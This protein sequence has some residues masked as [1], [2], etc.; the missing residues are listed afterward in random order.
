MDKGVHLYF[1]GR[2]LGVRRQDAW[3]TTDFDRPS[4]GETDVSSAVFSAGTLTTD[5]NPIEQRMV[6]P[7]DSIDS[8]LRL[9][10]GNVEYRIEGD[11]L[12]S[13]TGLR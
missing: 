7:A 5:K 12:G 3:G 1:T 4:G 6:P 9:G 2:G 10:V 13:P 8:A 11:L